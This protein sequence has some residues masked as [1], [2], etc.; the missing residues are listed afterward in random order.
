MA[1]TRDL[2]FEIG[3]EEMPSAPLMNAEKQLAALVTAG[4][5]E[6]GLAHGAVRTFS[7]PRRLT[8]LVADVADETEAV[9]EVLRGPAASIAFDEAGAPTRAAEGFARKNGIAAD[10]LIRRED[11]DGRE[12]VFAERSVEPVPAAPLLSTLFERI[13]ASL[14][15]PNYRSQR[16]GSTHETFVRPIRWIC[17]LLGEEPIPVRYADVTSGDTT[18]GHRVLAPGE[19]RVGSAS[20]YERVLE[21]AFVLGAAARADRIRAG[22]ARVE[23]E[24]GVT[25][26]TPRRVFDEVVN[27]CEWPEVLVGRF[28][29]EF[30]QV[31][32]EIICESML[33]NQRY[34]PTYDVAGNLTRAFVVV[35][36]AD[37]AVARTVID[38]NERVVRARL[39]DAKFF[40]EED[41]KVPLDEFRERLARVGFQRELGTVLQKSERIEDVA[42]AIAREARLGAKV[43]AAA[44][45]AAHLAKADL[46]SNAV[47]DF[48]SQQGVMGGYYALAA[49]E[50]ED[51]AEGIRDHYRP[52]FAGDDLP[53]G[54]C[55]CVVAVADKLDT[56]AGMFAIGEPPTGSKDPF[57][58]RRAAIGVVNILRDRLPIAFEPIVDAALDAYAAQ[59]LSFDRA[60]TTEAVCAFIRGRMQ[61]MARDEGLSADTVAA[62][63]AGSVTA[64]A[65]FFALARALEDARANDPAAF[66]NLAVA[67]ARAA[68]LADASLGTEVDPALLGPAEAALLAAVDAAGENVGALLQARDFAGVIAALAGLREAI[69]GFFDEV[70]V[71]DEDPALRGNRL[72]LLNRFAA[73]FADVANIGELGRR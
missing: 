70:M 52:R 51:V 8:A 21:G 9:H 29:E 15:W 10:E 17:A 11:A 13:I 47:V 49:G 30:L 65:D 20:D 41:L 27:L 46:V 3:V 37:P 1:G 38:G 45:R 26:D 19:H 24:L 4:L 28:D 53:A 39:A 14:E 67:H 22:I 56:I 50:G 63:S 48:T 43:A 5:D 68:H 35:S 59:G 2:L 25:V 54:V 42:L 34:F 23:A 60:A 61:Q 12:Y 62:V 69:D 7:T 31:P 64:P 58:L 55:G 6:A 36:N 73:L 18:R 33:T 57:A 66:E 16:W 40:Y 72:R 32:S 71:M 44:A